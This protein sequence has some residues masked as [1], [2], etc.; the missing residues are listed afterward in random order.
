MTNS[1]HFT[2]YPAIDLRQGQVVRLVQGDPNRQTIYNQDP[3]KAAH[4]WIEM[5]AKWLHVV[6]LDGAFGEATHQNLQ[7]LE[8][9]LTMLSTSPIEVSIQW[10]GGVRSLNDIRQLLSSG[11]NRVILGSAAVENPKIIAQALEEFGPTCLALAVD[12]KDQMVFIRGWVKPAEETPVK[13]GQRFYEMGLRTCIFTDISRDGG[14]A[15]LNIPATRQF[16]LDTGLEVIASGGVASIEDV[17]QSQAAGLSGVIIGK[18]LYD[19]KIS[20]SDALAYQT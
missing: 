2:I 6:N 12:V 5:G 7:A 19:Q 8:R 3:A 4:K 14:G 15:G 20:L 17:K 9:I 11:V 16:S 13:L 1:P 10:G 18:A